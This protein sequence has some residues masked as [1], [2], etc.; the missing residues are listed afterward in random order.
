MIKNLHRTSVLIEQSAK[1]I[2][3]IYIDRFGKRRF[4]YHHLIRD[5]DRFQEGDRLYDYNKLKPG[6]TAKYHHIQKRL[7]DDIINF[8]KQLTEKFDFYK[9]MSPED[10]EEIIIMLFKYRPWVDWT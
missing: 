3:K 10:Q 2:R 7:R 1:C 5:D 9:H 6:A 4:G 8:D